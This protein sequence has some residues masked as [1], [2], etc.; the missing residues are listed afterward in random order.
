[1]STL[2]KATKRKS[3]KKGGVLADALHKLIT[4]RH[5]HGLPL[6]TAAATMY[7][8]DT[9]NHRERIYRLAGALRKN[10]IMVFCFGGRYHLCNHDGI[11]LLEVA[12]KKQIL[13][14]S[15]LQNA[16]I[17]RQKA[18]E[19]GLPAEQQQRLEDGYKELKRL[20]GNLL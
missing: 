7:G 18:I 14:G 13:A 12:L 5:P 19:A 16:L 11:R 2:K 3:R 1:M 15:A 6:G 9:K 17:L 4:D 10:N 20:A 8:T